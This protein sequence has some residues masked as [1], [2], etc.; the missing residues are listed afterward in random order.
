MEQPVESLDSLLVRTLVGGRVFAVGGRVRDEFLAEIGRPQPQNPDLDYLVA[1]IS[2]DEV[3]RRLGAVGKA[4]LVG[5]SFGVI[6]FVVDGR[7]AD[8]ALPRRERAVGPKHRDFAVE[9]SPEIPLEEDLAR[10]D[11][12]M[13]MM[14]RALDTGEVIDPYDGRADLIDGRLDTLR[15]DAFVEDPLRVLRGAHFAARFNLS[16]TPATLAGMRAA[17][18]RIASVAPE[19]VA[20]ELSKLLIRSARP[21]V[22]IELLREVSALPSVLPELL[23]GWNVEQNEFHKY[24]VYEHSLVCC[25]AAPKTL[26]LRLAALLHD[27]GKPRTKEGPHFYRHEIV[28]EKMARAALTRLRF[29]NDLIDRVC[30]LIANHMYNS[31]EGLSDAAIRRFI[32]RVGT[33]RVDDMFELRHADVE[34]SGLEPRNPEQQAR[35]EARVHAQIAS[36]PPFGIKDLAIDGAGVKAVMNELGLVDPNFEGDAR[37]GAA[38]R[39]CL[40]QVLD[41][42]RK[43]EAAALREIVRGFFTSEP[44]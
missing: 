2:L 1:G 39:C 5:A 7:T 35:F 11:F 14:A 16:P 15:E 41:D 32:R 33:D 4:E 20:D 28:G 29:P 9:A 37:V 24:S 31:D 34:A 12:R 6:K 17:S 42:P 8:V 23:E 25:D 3:I 43:N 26:A 40:E 30:G 38:L 36:A 22:G 21:S 18:D 27:A 10:R 19:R 13:N 44:R